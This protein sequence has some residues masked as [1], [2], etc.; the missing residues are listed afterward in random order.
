MKKE[1]IQVRVSA[2]EKEIIEKL[3]KKLNLNTTD[4]IKYSIMKVINE[5]EIE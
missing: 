1:R 4:F 3:A 2:K 5:K